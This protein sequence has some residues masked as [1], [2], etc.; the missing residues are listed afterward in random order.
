MK[1]TEEIKSFPQLD[2][3]SDLCYN[4]E[5]IVSITAFKQTLANNFQLTS[6]LI[7]LVKITSMPKSA[8][9]R[10]INVLSPPN[11]IVIDTQP[12]NQHWYVPRIL[13]VGDKQ[14]RPVDI[15]LYLEYWAEEWC[16][17]QTQHSI[18]RI[19]VQQYTGGIISTILS[20]KQNASFF[21][22]IGNTNNDS[23]QFSPSCFLPYWFTFHDP[24]ELPTHALLPLMIKLDKE[25]VESLEV[26]EHFSAACSGA[27]KGTVWPSVFREQPP[28]ASSGASKGSTI[29]F[30][31]T[32]SS[33]WSMLFDREQFLNHFDGM[34]VISIEPL[35]KQAIE[36]MI[37]A[38]N[39]ENR[40]KL[41]YLK[42]FCHTEDESIH[43]T[44]IN[45][46]TGLPKMRTDLRDLTFDDTIA[47]EAS[48]SK[49]S[50]TLSLTLSEGS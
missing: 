41:N 31:T 10:I 46:N 1:N 26:T 47:E 14:F 29:F 15:T 6:R 3:I 4:N 23:S 50:R 44:S 19:D 42:L 18:G 17:E 43:V 13:Q 5:P 7:I 8:V 21:T 49:H 12:N 2:I 11:Y 28:L 24:N 39:K 40:E 38:A 16:K 37:K 48:S 27:V 9:T 32:V 45:N 34:T 25:T 36:G 20:K 30:L 22:F 35:T 33:Y